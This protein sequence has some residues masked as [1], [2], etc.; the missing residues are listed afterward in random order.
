MNLDLR[1]PIGLMFTIDG[2]LLTGF[3]LISDR[4]IY[5]RSLGI[6]VNLLWGLVLLV[7][8][9]VMLAFAMRRSR[10]PS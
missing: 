1:Y 8:G 9:V 6:N 3:G 4:A 5:D 7:F 10:R 2:V